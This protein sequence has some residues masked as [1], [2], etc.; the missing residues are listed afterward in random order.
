MER[1]KHAKAIED[2]S[3]KKGYATLAL[4][5]RQ[6]GKSSTSSKGVSRNQWNLY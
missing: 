5:T 3:S 1:T 4:L 6:K 2:V